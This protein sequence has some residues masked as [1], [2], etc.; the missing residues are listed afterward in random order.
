MQALL[1]DDTASLLGIQ[2]PSLVEKLELVA[3]LNA[4]R[5][6][7]IAKRVAGE[8]LLLTPAI[9]RWV[10]NELLRHLTNLGQPR[11]WNRTIFQIPAELAASWQAPST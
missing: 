1:G 5:V 3:V 6:G 11:G 4:V 8:D 10:S 9:W 2:P 7:A